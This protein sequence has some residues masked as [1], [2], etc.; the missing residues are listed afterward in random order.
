MPSLAAEKRAA[1]EAAAKARASAHALAAGAGRRAAGHF[2]A[3][4]GHLR[5]VRIVAGYLPFRS[6]IDPRP[7]MMALHGLGYGVCV[8]VIEGRGRPL[9]FRAWTPASRTERGP[10]GV[11]V[12]AEGAAVTPDLL[13]V[14]LLAF[15]PEGY[16]LGYG[17]GFYD[18][19]LAAGRAAGP[20]TAIG[21]AYA[22]QQVAR[23][24]HGPHDARLDAVA[25]EAGLVTCA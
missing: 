25:T 3:S 7:A 13:L 6:E 14:P 15:D 10:F 22:A 9:A 1:R 21:L 2:L 8:P 20:L 18:R 23:V 12:P 19:T 16:R 24:P 5:G 11:R 17:G 4:L